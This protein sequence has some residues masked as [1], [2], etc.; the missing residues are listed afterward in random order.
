M[1]MEI[2][3]VNAREYSSFFSTH[4]HVY[5]TM[6]FIQLNA[7]KCEKIHFL[8]FRNNKVRLGIILG[9]YEDRLES[10]FSAP[11]GGF[12]CASNIKIEYIECAVQLLIEYAQKRSKHIRIVLPPDV[13][14]M[15]LNAKIINAFMRQDEGSI[16]VDLN[17]HYEVSRFSEYE[18]YLS[19]SARKN[20]HTALTH[21]FDFH[22]LDSQRDDDISRVYEV[23]KAVSYTHLTLPTNVNV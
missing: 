20:F 12:D 3:E 19:R 5:N 8:L 6:A 21:C 16:S 10:P 7:Y 14:N 1:N 9:E 11:F 4:N 18:N 22:V 15:H 23:I 13:Y 2:I 17:Y